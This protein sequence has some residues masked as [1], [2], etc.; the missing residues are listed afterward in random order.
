[1]N[2]KTPTSTPEAQRPDASRRRM[3]L[4]GGAVARW[5]AA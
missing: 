5:P 1:M 2:D 3:L 4:R